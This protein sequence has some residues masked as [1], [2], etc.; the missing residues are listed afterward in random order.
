MNKAERIGTV[1]QFHRK[2]AG[3][4]RKELSELAGVGETTIYNVE[5]GRSVR[6]DTLLRLFNALNITLQLK[7]PVMTQI[8]AEVKSREP[9]NANR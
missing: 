1:I 2:V 8:E 4:T 5:H 6:L 9:E 3:L 7:S